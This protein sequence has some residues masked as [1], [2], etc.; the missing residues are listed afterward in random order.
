M[1]NLGEELSTGHIWGID[2]VFLSLVINLPLNTQDF[3]GSFSMQRAVLS[4]ILVDIYDE[5]KD[6]MYC[7][8]MKISIPHIQFVCCAL[9]QPQSK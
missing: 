7:L 5:N 8:E 2:E 9:V 3:W 4:P 1:V 6:E